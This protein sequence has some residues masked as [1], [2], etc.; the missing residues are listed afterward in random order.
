MPARAEAKPPAPNPRW[1]IALE[2]PPSPKAAGPGSS[3]ELGWGGG[4]DPSPLPVHGSP[5]RSLPLSALP[6]RLV[7]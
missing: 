7:W 3:P 1:G 6:D 4:S 2:H 5:S